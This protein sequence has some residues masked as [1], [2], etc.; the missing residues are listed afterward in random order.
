MLHITCV[1]SGR[2]S[3]KKT[4]PTLYTPCEI[5]MYFIHII[6]NYFIFKFMYDVVFEH[7]SMM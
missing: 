1:T 3:V 2:S 7:V 6:L 5:L 4:D